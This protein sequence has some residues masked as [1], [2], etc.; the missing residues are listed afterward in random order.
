MALDL[1]D[2]V[3]FLPV[4]DLVLARII[5]SFADKPSSASPGSWRMLDE[6]CEAESPGWTVSAVLLLPF[7]LNESNS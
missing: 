4:S 6:T 3:E 1:K 7:L 2:I 5:L